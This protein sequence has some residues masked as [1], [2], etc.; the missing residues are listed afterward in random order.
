MFT[1]TKQAKNYLADKI[2]K[3]DNNQYKTIMLDLVDILW[4]EKSYQLIRENNFE[5]DSKRSEIRGQIMKTFIGELSRD[6]IKDYIG[7]IFHRKEITPNNFVDFL[8]DNEKYFDEIME[9]IQRANTDTSSG[10]KEPYKLIEVEWLLC[11]ALKDKALEER[12]LK[13]AESCKEIDPYIVHGYIGN[14]EIDKALKYHEKK[15]MVYALRFYERLIKLW[16]IDK[17]TTYFLTN[18]HLRKE[19]NWSYNRQYENLSKLFKILLKTNQEKAIEF[20]T[21]P[22]I[23]KMQYGNDASKFIDIMISMNIGEDLFFKYITSDGISEKKYNVGPF[24]ENF[25]KI[26]KKYW[27]EFLKKVIMHKE[28]RWGRILIDWEREWRSPFTYFDPKDTWEQ[29]L[30]KITDIYHHW[31]IAYFD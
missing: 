7:K 31:L 10:K 18:E 24:S 1:E 28:G 22:A 30:K 26:G 19:F 16:H 12:I 5:L 2:N 13:K 20:I 6:G 14:K 27:T 15:W 9:R 25:G 17:V 29:M 23:A 3:S 4:F 8:K 11:N 21:N